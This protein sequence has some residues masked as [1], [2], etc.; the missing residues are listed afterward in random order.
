VA[1]YYKL[2]DEAKTHIFDMELRCSTFADAEAYLIQHALVV[3]FSVETAG[4]VAS[5]IDPFS[6]MYSPY[7]L[8]PYRYKGVKL[9]K[10]PMSNPE[11]LTAYTEWKDAWAKAQEAEWK[12][13]WARSQ[14]AQ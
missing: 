3:S 11:F 10:K 12:D 2:T 1:D 6:H 7:G 8:S 9:L 14:A 5:Y 13:A 4:Y